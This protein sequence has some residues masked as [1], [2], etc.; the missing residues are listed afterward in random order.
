MGNFSGGSGRENGPD[1]AGLFFPVLPKK[2]LS[3]KAEV[4]DRSA[5]LC[6][7]GGKGEE[8]L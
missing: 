4:F 5:A 8:R 7:D 3:K 1:L 2:V 6:N